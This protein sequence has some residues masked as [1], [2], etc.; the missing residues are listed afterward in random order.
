MFHPIVCLLVVSLGVELPGYVHGD[1]HL[2]AIRPGGQNVFS[3]EKKETPP[4]VLTKHINSV[5]VQTSENG[6]G[7]LLN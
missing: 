6:D 4:W 3:I 7:L 2:R 5:N 1:R